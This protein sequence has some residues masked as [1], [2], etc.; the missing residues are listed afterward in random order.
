MKTNFFTWTV[1]ISIGW[2]LT[3]SAQNVLRDPAVVQAATAQA[4]DGQPL[5]VVP[6][7][8]PRPAEGSR[9]GQQ[10]NTAPSGGP[11]SSLV[12][13]VRGNDAAL[14]VVVNQG[15]LITLKADIAS[16]NGLGAIAVGDPSVVEFQLLP[17]PRVIR[18]LGRRPGVTD[19]SITTVDGQSLNFEVRVLYDL[20]ILQAQLRQ[21]FPDAA[22]RLTQLRDHIIVEGEARSTA[23]VA[24]ILT[25]IHAFATHFDQGQAAGMQQVPSEVP[26]PPQPA[27]GQAGGGMVPGMLQSPMAAAAP[28]AGMGNATAVRIINLIRV[29][30]VRQVLLKVRVA[31]LNRTAIREIGADILGVNPATGTVVGTSIAGSTVSA[32]GVLGMGGLGAEASSAIGPKTTAFGIFP[33]ADFAILVRALRDNQLLSILAEPNLVALDGQHANFLA[34]GQFPVPVPQGSGGITNNVTVEFKDFGVQLDFIPHVLDDG[35][36][37][38]AVT[39]E[40]SSID[41]ALGTTLVQGGTPVPGLDT[42]RAT[43]TVEMGQGQTLAMAGLMQVQIEADTARIP[44]LGD[45]PII[46]VLFSNTSHKRMEKELV[47]LVTPFLVDP[48]NPNQVPCAPGDEVKDPTD[49]EFYLLN[50]VENRNG[51]EYRAT[52]G[53]DRPWNLKREIKVQR[54]CAAGPV[55]F[56]Q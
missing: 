51:T 1:V 2:T 48:M 22:L 8:N 44:G 52:L 34:G 50:R 54:D 40:V 33:T 5:P 6:L 37:R 11:V 7:V 28:S 27:L 20:G 10:W 19:L 15:R 18:L 9:P 25:M 24:Q 47:V 38:L 4:P 17:N 49:F 53:W 42:R 14:D 56:S 32:A 31:E 30:G 41:Y 36:I 16:R 55:G 3:T 26:P 13:S 46:G 21:A 39:P 23:Q 43:T 35:R 12:E 45:L 29:P